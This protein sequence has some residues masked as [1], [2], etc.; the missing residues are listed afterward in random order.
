[1]NMQSDLKG[2]CTITNVSFASLRIHIRVMGCPIPDPVKVGSFWFTG[3]GKARGERGSCSSATEMG[4]F[5][6]H[7]G[8]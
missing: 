5:L 7:A 4:M 3:A 1:M 8:F 2:L 6:I